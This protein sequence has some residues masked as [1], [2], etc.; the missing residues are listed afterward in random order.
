[1]FHW[2]YCPAD[3]YYRQPGPLGLLANGVVA[4]SRFAYPAAPL[5]PASLAVIK[6]G[7]LLILAMPGRLQQRGLLVAW[8][9]RR[10]G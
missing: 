4:R 5:L 9:A 1:M 7:G 2:C 6:C 10:N 3:F 8:G